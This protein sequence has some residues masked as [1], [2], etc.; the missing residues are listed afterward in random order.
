MSEMRPDMTAG[1]IDRN[2]SERTKT[3][4][5]GS[6]LSLRAAVSGTARPG[7]LTVGRP[8]APVTEAAAEKKSAA[9]SGLE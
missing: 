5:G 9:L 6:A 2:A 4:S 3:E 7:W 8:W 1:P